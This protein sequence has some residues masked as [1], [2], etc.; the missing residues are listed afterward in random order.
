[1]LLASLSSSSAVV[2]RFINNFPAF[3]LSVFAHYFPSPL[4]TSP[5]I[6]FSSLSFF[7]PSHLPSSVHQLGP[8]IGATANDARVMVC[9]EA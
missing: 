1:M 5:L 4:D 6:L 2:L 3:V 8:L 9:T 7:F